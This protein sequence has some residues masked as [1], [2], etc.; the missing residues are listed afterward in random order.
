MDIEVV[1]DNDDV[2]VVTASADVV[3]TA[4]ALIIVDDI[5]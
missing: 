5:R 1:T 3:A 4:I 2:N